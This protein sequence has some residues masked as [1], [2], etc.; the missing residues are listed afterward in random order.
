AGRQQPFWKKRYLEE[1]YPRNSK[2]LP[3]FIGERRSHQSLGVRAIHHKQSANERAV[4]MREQPPK[5][6]APVMRHQQ[7]SLDAQ[8]FDQ[9]SDIVGQRDYVVTALGVTCSRI[10]T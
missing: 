5:R 3:I 10:A 7:T 1:W 9:C 2:R 8:H 6:P 4:T